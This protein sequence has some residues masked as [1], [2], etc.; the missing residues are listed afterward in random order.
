MDGGE[1]YFEYC[2]SSLIEFLTNRLQ[3]EW[4]DGAQWQR[5]DSVVRGVKVVLGGVYRYSVLYF[6]LVSGFFAPVIGGRA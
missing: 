6:V 2:V 5:M 4:I 1:L 3:M